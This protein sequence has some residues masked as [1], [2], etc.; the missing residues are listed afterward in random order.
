MTTPFRLLASTVITMLGA[1]TLAFGQTQIPPTFSAPGCVLPAGIKSFVVEH[2]LFP[3]A[4]QSAFSA[5]FPDSTIAQLLDPTREARTH[6]TYDVATNI[7]RAWFFTVPKGSPDI[8][9]D[10]TNF[11]AIKFAYINAPAEKV[12]VTCSPRPT[13]MVIGPI[14]DATPVYGNMTGLGHSFSFTYDPSKPSQ[15]ANNIA[16]VTAGTVVVSETSGSARVVP[17]TVNAVITG[18]PTITTNSIFLVLDGSKSTGGALGYNQIGGNLRYTWTS[19]AGIAL[20]TPNQNQTL[21]IIGAGPGVYGLTLTVENE[22][23]EV[24]TTTAKLVYKP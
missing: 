18:A 24:N 19:D 17:Q 2:K 8:T 16:Y 23:G 4:F 21:A 13:V 20:I 22:L 10:T 7:L 15:N 6:L 12:Y 5:T 11:E 1:T 3:S 14:A 9:P